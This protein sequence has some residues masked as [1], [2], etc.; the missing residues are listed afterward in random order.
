[1][2][3]LEINGH[4]FHGEELIE[5]VLGCGMMPQLIKEMIL[6]SCTADINLTSEEKNLAQEQVRK[7]LGI[8][9]SDKLAVWL[10]HQG[11]TKAQLDYRSERSLKLIKFKQTTWGAKINSAFLERKPQLDRVIYSLIRLKDFCA[12]QE[13]YFRIKEGEQSFDELARQYSQGSE[14]ETGGLVGPFEMGTIHPSI[15]KILLSLDVGQVQAPII[16]DDWILILR[17]EQLISASLDAV[18]H[19]KLID[20]KFNQWLEENINR[21]MATLVIKN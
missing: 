19:Q 9:K 7:Q 4:R 5:K 10:K 2:P 20:E 13:L 16:V 18:T 1:M 12:A 15:Q 11:I 14:A 6:D 8:E 3:V 17:L 21:Q